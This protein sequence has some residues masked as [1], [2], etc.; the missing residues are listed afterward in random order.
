MRL[1]LPVLI[2]AVLL[3]FAAGCTWN[4]APSAA[5]GTPPVESTPVTGSTPAPATAANG[6]VIAAYW[7]LYP[8]PNDDTY[9]LVMSEKDSIPWKK[10]NR[11]YIGFAT[12]KDGVL[13]DL[14]IGDS[15]DNAT[16]R[17]EMQ[18]RIHEIVALCRE[19]NPEA[20]IFITSNF[21]EKEL[22]PQYLQAAQDPQKFADSVL[23]YLK[24]YDLDGYDMDWESSR[25][26]EYAPQLTSLLSAC[27]AAFAA[28][29]TNPHG[30][31]YKLTHTV[32]P[33]VESAE[34]VAGLNDSVDQINIMSYGTGDKYDLV[35]YADSYAAAGFPYG[36]M[37]GGV[38]SESAY[39]DNVGPDTQGSVAVKCAYVKEHNLAG[40][41]AWRMDNDMRPDN[42]P[43][44]Y[45]VTGW[46]YDC[47]SQ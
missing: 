42:S 11:L 13:T 36:K 33:G 45:Q 9:T 23:A 3:L 4:S 18:R 39:T 7:Y 31:P 35:S 40:L 29:G 32:W 28:A 8:D 10:I 2:I 14:P 44:T 47:L 17:A 5:T 38:E 1:T 25:I 37:I 22:D 20:E 26:D 41:F 6:N 15:A 43:P 19:N 34:T 46:V 27:H 12:V 16:Q 21:D 30:Q 24:E